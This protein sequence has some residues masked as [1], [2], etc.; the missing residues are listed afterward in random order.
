LPDNLAKQSAAKYKATKLAEDALPA[1]ATDAQIK[2]LAD[3]IYR[4]DLQDAINSSITKTKLPSSN[5]LQQVK[6]DAED[7]EAYRI[8]TDPYARAMA[9]GIFDPNTGEEIFQ[10]KLSY[11]SEQVENE[12]KLRAG[13]FGN[14]YF[15]SMFQMLRDVSANDNTERAVNNA[16]YGNKILNDDETYDPFAAKA[17]AQALSG[18]NAA[19]PTSDYLRDAQN[20]FLQGRKEVRI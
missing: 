7:M 3:K 14:K 19:L 11:L 18:E 1:N 4:S 17:F 6:Q 16:L 13:N 10:G 15:D 9:L 5:V 2:D 20:A 8:M 12:L